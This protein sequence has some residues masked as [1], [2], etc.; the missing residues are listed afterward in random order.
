VTAPSNPNQE[1]IVHP[2]AAEHDYRAIIVEG[3]AV[4]GAMFVGPPGTG[5]LCSELIERRP[6]L[7]PI[8]ADLR[9]GDWDALEKAL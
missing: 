6:D 2:N 1:A 4:V 5:K 9:G 8:L 7:T 3:G